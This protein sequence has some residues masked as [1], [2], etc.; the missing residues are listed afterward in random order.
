MGIEQP[1]IFNDHVQA[2]CV[3]ETEEH[4]Q[5]VGDMHSDMLQKLGFTA[6]PGLYD[7]TNTTN[8]AGE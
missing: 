3:S 4:K 1:A 7:E 5:R 2:L 8:K 6:Q